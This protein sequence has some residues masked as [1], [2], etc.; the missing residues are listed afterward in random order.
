MRRSDVQPNLSLPSY[1]TLAVILREHFARGE[2]EREKF[3][4]WLE[5]LD[6]R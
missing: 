5:D 3:L 6:G 1:R 2:I 4:Q